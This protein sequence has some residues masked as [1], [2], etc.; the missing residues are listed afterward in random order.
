MTGTGVFFIGEPELVTGFRY[1]GV[2][3]EVALTRGEVLASFQRVQGGGEKIVLFSRDAADL[4][5]EEL[6]SWQYAGAS[7][8]VVEVP[9]LEGG[10]TPSSSLLELIREALGLPV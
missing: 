3:G 7:P 6:T 4:I 9:T 5:R 1:A 10:G 2:P 8:L